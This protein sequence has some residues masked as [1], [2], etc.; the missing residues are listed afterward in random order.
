[1]SVH[2]FKQKIISSRRERVWLFGQLQ[3]QEA[4]EILVTE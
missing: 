3:E 2:Y 1:M 4:T